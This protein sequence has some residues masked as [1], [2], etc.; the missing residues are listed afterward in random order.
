MLVYLDN[1]LNTKEKPQENFARELMELFSMGVGN[2]T[3]E[4]VRE[5]AR[6]LTGET[7]NERPEEQ[8]P[9]TYEFDASK[10]DTGPKTVFG[11][12]I[13]SAVPGE[14]AN[15]VIDLIMDR[16]SNAPI[17]AAHS[18]LP[19]TS[20]YMSWKF[21][22]WFVLETIPIDHSAVEE[23]AE[24][25]YANQAEGDN[26]NVRET[27]RRLLKSQFFFDTAHRSR[28]YKHPMDY[29]IMAARNLELDKWL[30][31]TE[32]A[33]NKVRIPVWAAAMGM[34]LLGAPN[35]SG[36]KHGREWINTGNLISRFNL[37]NNMSDSRYMTDA[38]CDNLIANGHV[39]NAGDHAGIIEF[40]RAR[41]IQQRLPFETA[42]A[43][44]DFL[45]GVAGN[46]GGFHRKVRGCFHIMMT[47]PQYQMK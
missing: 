7:L 8:W 3:E 26:Y 40:F 10:H 38:W 5:I 14:E 34:Q 9:F 25:F 45:N 31:E 4:D 46:G 19:A 36:W 12:T 13:Q 27:L 1:R 20:I 11:Q 29:M 37:A 28:M 15:Q 22:K 42:T 18:R 6:A 33:H 35:V 30:Y 16:V 47:S 23:L 32:W 24:F 2:Y 39:D 44:S 41:L 21:I 17:S 43:L